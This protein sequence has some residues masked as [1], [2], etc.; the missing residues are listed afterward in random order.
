MTTDELRDEIAQMIYEDVTKQFRDLSI[1]EP[2]NLADAI[3]PIIARERADAAQAALTAAADYKAAWRIAGESA[4]RF[5]DVVSEAL[6]LDENPGDDELIRLLRAQHGKQG[7]EP[8]RWRDFITGAEAHLE[9][10]GISIGKRAPEVGGQ[11]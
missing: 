8:R 11:R 9:R 2:H 5:R 1:Y 7:P 10:N 4:D 6:D 3:L